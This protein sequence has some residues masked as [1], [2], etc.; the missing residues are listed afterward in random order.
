MTFVA[1]FGLPALFD[2][3]GWALVRK[4]VGFDWTLP[5]ALQDAQGAP[6]DLP[7]DVTARLYI[8]SV[9][10]PVGLAVTDKGNGLYQTNVPDTVTANISAQGDAAQT[11]PTRVV[12]AVEDGDGLVDPVR[13]I[14][15]HVLDPRSTTLLS[16]TA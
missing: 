8:E 7:G 3:T 13:I 11:F 15:I 1:A 10:T 5:F 2:P 9:P 14:L 12:I 4:C 16:R 6:L